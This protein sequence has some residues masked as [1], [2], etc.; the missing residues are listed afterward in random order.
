LSELYRSFGHQTDFILCDK[1]LPLCFECNYLNKQESKI[2]VSNSNDNFC[3]GCTLSGKL[4]LDKNNVVHYIS[5]YITESEIVAFEEFTNDLD[6]AHLSNLVYK[7]TNLGEHA[8]SA[9][10]RF[11]A[12]SKIHEIPYE[13]EVLRKYLTSSYITK[14]T[15][16]RI[17]D[18]FRPDVVFTIHGLYIPHGVIAEICR[19]KKIKIV[20]WNLGYRK[21]TFIFSKNDTYHRTLLKTSNYLWESMRW[22][23]EKELI[24]RNYLLSRREG[25]DDW[26]SF[27][28]PKGNDEEQELENFCK[29][30]NK[31]NIA[32]LLTNVGWDA[33]IHY[34]QNI[35][36]DMHDWLKTTIDWFVSRPDKALIIRVHPAEITSVYPSNEKTHEI[37]NN[38]YP[39]L[40]LNI[41]IIPSSNKLDT[42]FACSKSN[43]ILIYGTKMGVELAPSEK[44]IIVA[45][46][47][48]IKN[49]GLTWDPINKADYLKLLENFSDLNLPV[50][51]S[52]ERALKYAYFFF[53][54][55]FKYL[56]G[57]K[58]FISPS[59]IVI[60]RTSSPDKH[61]I[62]F[63]LELIS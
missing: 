18:E 53:M 23:K 1:A 27:G 42:Y 9:T 10:L 44:K 51:Y 24:I 37:L 22:D 20:V 39:R 50:N 3:K 21:N 62:E 14:I 31:N 32:V 63:L 41:K 6:T 12:K 15:F 34:E 40:P 49:K 58:K 61:Q 57:V 59:C 56:N 28:H 38:L 26:I 43:V 35:F 60:N 4:N 29:L 11:L 19:K 48:W 25:T 33:Q 36:V 30:Y 8:K 2:P 16:E 54:E 52:V 47:A 7:G 5:K 17:V 13:K 55:Q 46:E 45:G